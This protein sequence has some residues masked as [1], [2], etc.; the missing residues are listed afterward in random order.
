MSLL[1]ASTIAH[2]LGWLV[3]VPPKAIAAAGGASVLTGIVFGFFPLGSRLGSIPLRRFARNRPA[4]HRFAD[5]KP[6][7]PTRFRRSSRM[8]AR[9]RHA[10]RVPRGAALRACRRAPSRRGLRLGRRWG[11]RWA[12]RDRDRGGISSGMWFAIP[13]A[14]L[15]AWG[16]GPLCARI[17]RT[18]VPSSTPSTDT[19]RRRK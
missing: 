2:L 14:V 18:A 6:S 9:A 10:R 4:S 15:T 7:G 11:L 19:R 13:A 5:Q 3:P 17:A 12:G 16:A 8:D 1:G